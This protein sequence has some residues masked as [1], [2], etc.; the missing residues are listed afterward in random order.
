MEIVLEKASFNDIPEINQIQKNAFKESFNNYRF[1]PAY[2]ITNEQML[3]YFEKSDV[4]KILFD[5]IIVG[6]IFIYKIANNHYELDTIS[7]RPD[8]QNLGIGYKAIDIVEKIYT[9]ASIWTLLT[10]KKELR[11]R[12]LYERLKY[13]QVG[14]EVVNE[15]L[16][17]IHYEKE[18]C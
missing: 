13:R 16:T 9:D 15:Y 12:R 8:F 17:L 3:T 4:Y 7:I 10:P 11:N 5:G 6:S 2:E 18:L 14:E 1:C